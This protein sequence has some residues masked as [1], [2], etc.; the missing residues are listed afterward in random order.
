MLRLAP[1]AYLRFVQAERFCATYSGAEANVA[2]SLAN[3]GVDVAFVS[4]LAENEIGQSAVNYLRRFGVNTNYI[5]RC[6]DGR[7]GVYFLEKGASQRP[8]K[9]I[10]DRAGSAVS[11]SSSSDYDWERIFDGAEIFMLSGIT[12]AL[13][14]SLAEI[15]IQACKI[16]QKKGIKVVFDLNYRKKLW[17]SQKAGRVMGEI[18]KNVDICI[19]NEE[20]ANAVFGIEI[21]QK[22]FYNLSSNGYESVARELCKKFNFKKVCVTLRESK[23]ASVNGWSGLIFDGEDCKSYISKK[24]DVQIVDRV[25]SGDSFAA[26]IIFGELEKMPLEDEVNFAVAASCL[27]HSVEGDFNMASREEVF[28]LMNGDSSGRVKR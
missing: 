26:G 6:K 14:D 2:V 8:S 10:Y 28:A 3:F 21:P 20:D 25:G 12:P 24:Y 4:K 27:K 17:D 9:V 22:Q 13:S 15:C 1:E 5:C 16:A 19:T 7:T 18:C 23:S 11:L